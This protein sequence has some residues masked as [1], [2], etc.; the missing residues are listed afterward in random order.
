MRN[1]KGQGDSEEA[2]GV[3][4]STGNRIVDTD[5]G[6]VLVDMGAS[7]SVIGKDVLPK[8]AK[9]YWTNGQISE[10]DGRDV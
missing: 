9:A 8:E 6:K 5:L 3:V 1:W 10:A 2:P 7:V 4:A